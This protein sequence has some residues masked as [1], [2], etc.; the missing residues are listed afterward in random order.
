[1]RGGGADQG[2]LPP[3]QYGS[4]SAL[5]TIELKDVIRRDL[6]SH[7][8]ISTALGTEFDLTSIHGLFSIVQT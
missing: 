5:R 1:M 7:D 3:E 8:S 6:P 4:D 2:V